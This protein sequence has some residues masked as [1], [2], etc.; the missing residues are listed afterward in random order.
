MTTAS[1]LKSIIPVSRFNKGEAGQIF[2]ELTLDNTKIVVKNNV[3]V[4]VMLSPA[5]YTRIIEMN[6]DNI[7]ITEAAMRIGHADNK[8]FIPE[9]DFLTAIGLTEADIT[10]SDDVE[11]E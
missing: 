11:I 8:D 2:D 7:L 1:V 6:E 9:A 5:E 3:P 10:N 4:A